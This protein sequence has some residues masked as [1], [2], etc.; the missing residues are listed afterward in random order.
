[1][2]KACKDP[3]RPRSRNK[4]QIWK[5]PKIGCLPKNGNGPNSSRQ[6]GQG[7]LPPYALTAVLSPV[8]KE[9]KEGHYGSSFNRKQ[10]WN[11]RMET[12]QQYNFQ[13]YPCSTDWHQKRGGKRGTSNGVRRL[14]PKKREES[15]PTSILDHGS[16]PRN[17]PA[18]KVKDFY[19]GHL[20]NRERV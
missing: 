15:G 7:K 13:G 8:G 4:V 16:N 1:M 14:K 6:G 12:N 5:N 20:R 2:K 19:D 18:H 17:A 3:R 11:K 9:K 10:K